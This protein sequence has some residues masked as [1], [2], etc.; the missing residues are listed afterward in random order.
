MPDTAASLLLMVPYTFRGS[1]CSS[2]IL[3]YYS[4]WGATSA[5]LLTPPRVLGPLTLPP[6]VRTP[7]SPL[8]FGKPL[9]HLARKLPLAILLGLPLATPL[10]F[11][12]DLTNNAA[13]SS[14]AFL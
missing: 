11:L 9:L 6:L 8:P 4:Y 7:F 12:D 5:A 2:R 13:F 3:L 14:N 10:P 1:K